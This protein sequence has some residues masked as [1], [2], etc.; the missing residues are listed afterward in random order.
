VRYEVTDGAGKVVFFPNGQSD[1]I[2]ARQ[3]RMTLTG[4]TV[5]ITG[6][7]GSFGHAIVARL[8]AG[9]VGRVLVYSAAT[10]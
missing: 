4:L 10:S 9:D 1:Q 7:T 5:L 8:L 3:A 6:G 2:R